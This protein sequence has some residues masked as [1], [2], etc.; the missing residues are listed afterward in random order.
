MS[1]GEIL[2]SIYNH[3]RFKRILSHVTIILNSQD[4]EMKYYSIFQ[5]ATLDL[6][7]YEPLKYDFLLINPGMPL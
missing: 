7:I 3:S 6:A 4:I 5:Y 2:L 1:I